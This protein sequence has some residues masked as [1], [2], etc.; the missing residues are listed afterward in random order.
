LDENPTERNTVRLRLLFVA[1]VIANVMILA[2]QVFT[3]DPRATA[4][5]RIEELQINPGRI[6]LRDAASRGPGAQAVGGGKSSRG[7]SYR[8]CLEW[9]PFSGPDVSRADSALARLTLPHPA[10]QRPLSE[11]DGVKRFA[12]FVRDPDAATVAEIAELQKTFP[13]TE[14][15]AG[16]CPT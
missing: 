12:F 5:A 11:I 3:H 13:G 1:L 8:A 9:G 16:P 15:K 14:I 7:N 2:Y 10:L 4:A 6:K